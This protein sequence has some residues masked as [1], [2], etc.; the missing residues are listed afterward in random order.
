MFQDIMREIGWI[1]KPRG[2][3]SSWIC[4]VRQYPQIV[5]DA[6]LQRL[7]QSL[8]HRTHPPV[9]FDRRLR[10]YLL[11][12]LDEL[13][14]KPSS[15]GSSGWRAERC[16][17]HDWA[18]IGSRDQTVGQGKQRASMASHWRARVQTAAPL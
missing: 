11:Q 6:P 9:E 3:F 5:L 4:E 8:E 10:L 18:L 1:V 17:G 14:A 7:G 16:G 12:R 2:W 15:E 13:D